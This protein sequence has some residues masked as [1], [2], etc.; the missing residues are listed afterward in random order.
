MMRYRNRNSG[1]VAMRQSEPH[2]LVVDDYR[3]I[4]ES[5][6][7]YLRKHGLRVSLAADA[8]ARATGAFARWTR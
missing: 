2:I 6:A 1:L 5:L 8:A 3:D 4:Q 7:A